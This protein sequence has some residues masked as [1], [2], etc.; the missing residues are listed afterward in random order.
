MDTGQQLTGQALFIRVHELMEESLAAYKNYQQHGKT[1]QY[2]KELRRVNTTMV[3]LLEENRGLLTWEMDEASAA[4]TE[5]YK[6][7]TT[8]WDELEKELSPSATDEFVFQ[9]NYTFP[10][11]AAQL[12]EEKYLSLKSIT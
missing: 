6:I 5:H 3:V 8:K 7:W 12:F 4:L 1:Y 10:K 9:N 11:A 2:A